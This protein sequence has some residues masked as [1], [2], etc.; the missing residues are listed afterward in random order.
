MS[1]CVTLAL[2]ARLLHNHCMFTM[3]TIIH[4]RWREVR[5]PRM[6]QWNCNGI[7][8]GRA[9]Y[10]E[11]PGDKIQCSLQS[12]LRS[13]RWNCKG[14]QGFP[15]FPVN[16]KI[17][18]FWPL[19]PGAAMQ[20]HNV[21]HCSRRVFF[22]ARGVSFLANH[23]WTPWNVCYFH[24]ICMHVHTHV[25]CMHVLHSVHCTFILNILPFKSIPC[26]LVCLCVHVYVTL[27]LL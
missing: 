5:F 15:R 22:L 9:L 26:P 10:P 24:L 17:M 25:V 18:Y 11:C 27:L 2:P 4:I 6:Y 12:A 3:Y 16:R 13:S 23:W 21:L 20:K 14:T 19:G 8:F 1:V 7:L